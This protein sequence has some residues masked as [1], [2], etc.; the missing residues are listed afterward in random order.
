M[1]S[2][3]IKLLLLFYVFFATNVCFAQDNTNT[4][5]SNIGTVAPG[6]QV[7]NPEEE[8][9]LKRSI[10]SIGTLLDKT[11][12]P[13]QRQQFYM[14]RS[15]AYLRLGQQ[16]LSRNTDI[17]QAI[18]EAAPFFEKAENDAAAILSIPII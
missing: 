7:L 13:E 11:T 17:K 18:R 3:T 6:F 5:A 12:N 8:L 10:D 9:D 4:T 16:I 2:K 15:L 1:R 14:T